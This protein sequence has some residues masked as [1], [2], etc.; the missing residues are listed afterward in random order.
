MLT[1][2]ARFL[3]AACVFACVASCTRPADEPA[4]SRTT[5]EFAGGV[6]RADPRFGEVRVYPLSREVLVAL[7]SSRPSV[8]EWQRILAV[9][10]A[11]HASADSTLPLLGTYTTV[12]DTLRFR[13]RFP[14]APGLSYEA[15]FDGGALYGRVRRDPPASLT[16]ALATTWRYDAPATVPSTVVREIYPTADVLPMNLLRMYV[17]F[18][19]PMTSGRSYDFVKLYAEGDSLVEEPFFTA[20]GAV[21]LWDPQHTRLTIL[22]DPGRIKRDLK[23]HEEM[24]LPLRAG[25]RYRLVIDRTWRDAEGRPLVRAFVKSFRAGPQ[26]RSLVRTSDWRLTAPRAETRDSL[27]V[28]FPEPLDRALL[29]RLVSVHD[30]SG[31]AVD[32]EIVVSDRETRWA[33]APRNPWRRTAHALR[34]DTELEDLAGNNLKKLF[35]V[36]PADT[37]ATGANAAVVR[38]TFHTK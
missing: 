14:P 18:S 10:L 16:R 20:G 23:P 27:I 21:E 29:T 9:R 26:D 24:G 37:A 30:S 2:A 8:E 15:R 12:A 38:V 7:E 11:A 28:T 5:M 1:H 35:D 25:K 6:G 22:F 36:G 4:S 33:F 3:S 31:A 34:V 32:G 13:P 19:A 17:E